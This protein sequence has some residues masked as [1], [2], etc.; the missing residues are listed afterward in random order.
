MAF[1]LIPL[2]MAVWAA[3]AAIGLTTVGPLAGGMFAAA[4]AAG[5]VGAGTMLAAT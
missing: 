2:G 1:L 4:Q 5:Y 3:P